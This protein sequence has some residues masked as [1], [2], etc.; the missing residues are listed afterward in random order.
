L[1]DAPVLRFVDVAFRVDDSTI[2]D[3]VDWEVGRG[4]RWVV[5][6]ANGAGKTTLLRIGACY[7]H[8]T[9]GTVDVLGRRLGRVDVRALREHVAFSSSAIAAALEPRMTATEVVMTGRY[10]ELA[11]WWRSWTPEDRALARDLLARFGCDALASHSFASLSAGERQRVL[12]ARTLACEPGVV[13][14]DEP[15]AGPT[16]VVV[17]ASSPIS[18]S[19]ER[20]RRARRSSS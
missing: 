16:W 4:E 5:L 10:A 12:L 3:G 17:S 19:G 11:P 8:P 13:L 15:T 1:N 20:T 2:L 18:R 6:G 7:Q 14:L 9:R